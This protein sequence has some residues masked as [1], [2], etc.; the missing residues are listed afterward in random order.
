MLAGL[1]VACP[2]TGFG[3]PT[4]TTQGVLPGAPL[5]RLSC[6]HCRLSYETSENQHKVAL[7]RGQTKFYC[8]PKCVGLSQ[9]VP[10][11]GMTCAQCG[12]VFQ[13]PASSNKVSKSG[14]RF[15]TRK[16]G[17]EYHGAQRK[18]ARI[19]NPPPVRSPSCKACGNSILAKTPKGRWRCPCKGPE[20]VLVGTRTKGELFASRKGYQ[21]ARSAIQKMARAVFFRSNPTPSCGALLPSGQPCGYTKHIEVCHRRDVAD[22]PDVALVSEIN[23]AIN[24][25]GLCPTHHWEF[26]NDALDTPLV[27]SKALSA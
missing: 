1:R 23:A 16:C 24:M 11:M 26:D 14:L 8:S 13:R 18:H 9:R 27:V 6:N 17:S 10:A 19:N 3:V 25:V 20:I 5:I 4:I 15:C 2:I 22:F 7:W 21:S 12:T